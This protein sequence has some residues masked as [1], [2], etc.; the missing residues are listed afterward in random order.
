MSQPVLQY[1]SGAASA[2]SRDNL[3]RRTAHGFVWLIAQTLGSKVVGMAGQVVLAWLLM[4]ADLGLWAK[5]SI[6]MGFSGLIQQAGLRETLIHRQRTYHLWA[7][8]A[9]WMSVGLG[10]LGG[11]LTAAAAWPAAYFFHE[12][13]LVGILLVLAISA[14]L[15]SLDTVAEAKLQNQMRFGLLAGVN[16]GVAVAQLALTVLFASILPG[17]YKA[18]SFVLPR[19]IIALSRLTI[20]WS[21][22][23]PPVK[24]DPDIRRWKYL[25]SD[26]ATLFLSNLFL[27]LQWQG[28]YIVLGLLFVDQAILGVYFL[29][30]NLSIQ[31][32]QLFTGNLTGVLFPALSKLQS[33][34]KRQI[35][36][37]LDATRM[38]ALVAVPLCFLQMGVADP[39]VRMFFQDNKWQDAIPVL[40][41]LSLGMAFRVVAS[42]GGSLI[43][44]QGRFR[45]I[46]VTNII[47]AVVFLSLV[48][49]GALMGDVNAPSLWHRPATT[50]GIAVA[51]YFALIGPIFLY[52]A[53]HP[54]GGTWRDIWH[55]YVAPMFASVIAVASAMAIGSLVPVDQIHGHR[56]GHALRFTVIVAWF[57]A[58]YIPLVRLIAP[59]AWRALLQ[60]LVGLYRGRAADAET[61]AV[62]TVNA[63]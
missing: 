15:M 28:D 37:F 10:I 42:P 60:R 53:I 57:V 22:A 39:G 16:W 23:R 45:V 34:P 11:V 61:A 27:M 24:W 33:D 8:T 14:P 50:V 13:R 32:M 54:S 31:T 47:N 35:R 3:A 12:P 43:Q 4:P 58:A 26:S 52:V 30:F 46:L 40:Q 62:A 7:N 20:L 44:A 59:D 48:T 5:A 29:A 55:V 19:P 36:A 38:L 41:A 9:F 25:L 21:A 49:I 6:V 1:A 63:T 17:P 51:V 18:Y 56:W 2:S